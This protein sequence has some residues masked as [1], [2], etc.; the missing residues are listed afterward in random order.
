M[1]APH[2]H[3]IGITRRE[4]LQIG[5]T[6][7]LGLGLSSAIGPRM[8]SAAA[9]APAKPSRKPKSVILVFLTGAP[10]HIDTFDPKPDAP[11][12]I[13]GEFGTIP[14]TVSGLR[15]TDLLPKLATRADKYAIVRTLAH[16]DNNHTA[17]THHLIT[18]SKQPGVRFDKPLSR[19]DWPCYSAGVSFLRPPAPEVPA[20]VTLPTFLAEGPLV[21]PGQHAGFLGPRHDPWQITRDPNA[22]DFTVDNLRI[23]SGMDVDQLGDR[24]TLLDQVN[25]QQ[26]WLAETAEGRR[27]SDQQTRAFSLLTSG[28][29]ARAFEMERESAATRDKY[30][31]HTFGQS[32]LL[33][34][35][36]VQAGVPVVQ[37][38][39]GR[40]QNWDTHGNNFKRMKNELVPPVDQGVSALLDDLSQSGLLDETL[41]VMLGEF[42][43]TPK[44]DAK[45]AGRDHWAPC[46]F[47]LFAG[48]GV[49]GGQVIGKSDKIGAY[50]TTTPYSPDD[51]GATVYHTLG[52][53]PATEVRDRLNRPV[54]LNRGQVIQSLFTGA[55]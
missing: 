44:V 51:V 16:K 42:G 8:A 28:A 27:M 14:T 37:A 48:A 26:R 31:R 11:A 54:Q 53:D 38:N 13:R 15:V 24:R 33:A 17:A 19:D 35:R 45:N 32:L 21:W 9:E 50:P 36:L 3:A 41:V 47:G 4:T 34:R 55:A 39:M 10:S 29:V 2:R 22:K 6:G 1:T 43:R 20:G 30:G 7:L 18:G 49:R 46:F 40:V 12:E 5:Y 25:R 52:I 23:A